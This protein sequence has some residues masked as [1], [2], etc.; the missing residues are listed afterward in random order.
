MSANCSKITAQSQN[1]TKV[2]NTEIVISEDTRRQDEGEVCTNAQSNPNTQTGKFS[3]INS[4][5][6]SSCQASNAQEPTT[7]ITKLT[8]TSDERRIIIKKRD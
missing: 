8:F 6:K 1:S 5:L 4:N 3:N 2:I 7:K